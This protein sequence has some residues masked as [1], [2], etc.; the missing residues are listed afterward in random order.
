MVVLAKN[1]NKAIIFDRNGNKKFIVAETTAKVGDTINKYEGGYNLYTN[2]I[3][4]AVLNLYGIN[5]NIETVKMVMDEVDLDDFGIF[6]CEKCGKT[7][8]IDNL[9][10]GNEYGIK[11]CKDCDL[12]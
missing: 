10:V 1:G 4:R 3:S 8:Y 12:D 9:C 2:D 6:E 7:K 5:F 11:I